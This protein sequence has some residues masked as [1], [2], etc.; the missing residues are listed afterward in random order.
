MA[1]AAGLDDP[2]IVGIHNVIPDRM[3]SI[4]SGDSSSPRRRRP[5]KCTCPP[6]LLQDAARNCIAHLSCEG[7]ECNLCKIT[8]G[9]PKQNFSS[10][11]SKDGHKK[12]FRRIKDCLFYL[13]LPNPPPDRIKTLTTYLEQVS[14]DSRLTLDQ[15]RCIFEKIAMLNS[16]IKE[17]VS[18]RSSVRLLGSVL[19]GLA[20]QKISNVNLDLV[21]NDG[22][23]VNGEGTSNPADEENPAQ[24]LA[25]IHDLM[26]EYPG[27][28]ESVK[29][30]FNANVPR[31]SFEASLP[32]ARN[33]GKSFK[34]TFEILLSGQKSFET[35][36]LI[37]KYC[38]LDHR[39]KILGHFIRRWVENCYFDNQETGSWP[40]HSFMLMVISFLQK[41]PDPVLPY[42]QETATD[43]VPDKNVDFDMDVATPD[44]SLEHI[45]ETEWLS[46][47]SEPVG[48]LLIEFFKY[49]SM[50]FRGGKHVVSVR[51][52]PSKHLSH[53]DKGWGTEILAI[54]EPFRPWLNLS[55][56]VG[57]KSIFND[58]LHMMRETYAYFC[59]PQ[60]PEGPCYK[61][62]QFELIL[63]YQAPLLTAIL[64]DLSIS[65]DE[66]GDL[67]FSSYDSEPDEEPHEAEQNGPEEEKDTSAPF[68]KS[69]KLAN[70][71]SLRMKLKPEIEKSVENIDSSKLC[72]SVN[73][74]KKDWFRHPTKFCHVCRKTGHVAKKC[75]TEELPKLDD[76]PEAFPPQ[77]LEHYDR[78]FR[79]IY[80]KDRLSDENAAV[81]QKISDDL[82]KIVKEMLHPDAVVARFGSST[83]G[84]GRE[85]SDLDLCLTLSSNIT[86]EGL[87]QTKMIEKLAEIIKIYMPSID[88]RSIVPITQAKVPIVKFDVR[89]QRREKV[90]VYRCDVSLY[91]VLGKSNT[92]LLRTYCEIDPRVSLL[93]LIVKCFAE[94]SSP[95]LPFSWYKLVFGRH[96]TSRT[97]RGV[98]CPHTPIP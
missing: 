91:N 66:N 55:R 41:R 85:S 97:P 51:R 76:L 32:D 22:S 27:D 63:D 56:S 79:N 78:M 46:T 23:K 93:G 4:S 54:E 98:A 13:Q 86:G 29:K 11:V 44:T 37:K 60:L 57:N 80:N 59:I 64:H 94:V 16:L 19:T 39:V 10:H 42:L 15:T 33:Q 67:G 71:H 25:R 35:S 45:L 1:S 84:F 72:Y 36:A 90:V 58:F 68:R 62:D 48:K 65:S 6:K 75:P 95:V 70:Q 77:T 96:A 7:Y 50:E 73:F 69:R 5:E 24:V 52:P 8:F 34:T 14:L 61:K 47:N 40:P 17:H 74:R 3:A 12:Q 21:L 83:S 88:K 20:V 18:G 30:D 53:N 81:H 89:L 26:C 82:Q 92:G 28:F 38:E 31:V 49:Y 2:S 9:A 43:K 87:D